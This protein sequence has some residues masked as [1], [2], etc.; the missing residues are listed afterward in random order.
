MYTP[1]MAGSMRLAVALSMVTLAALAIRIAW[2]VWTAP[3]PH[4]LA[5]AD[6]YNATAI[7]LSRGLGY[8]VTFSGDQGFFPG[9]DAS[10]FWPPGYSLF[11]AAFY[12]LFG[13]DLAV[14]RS[15]N[16]IAGAITVVPI[17]FIGRRL[18]DN[19]TGIS[20]A[21][22]AAILPSFIF[23]TP[24]LLSDT[25][26]TLLFATSVACLLQTARTGDQGLNTGTLVAAGVVTGVAALVRGQTFVLIPTAAVW[27]LSSGIRLRQV[28]K[29][30]VAF[31]VLVLLVVT[32][33][34]IRNITRFDSPILLSSNFGY[35][36]R[37]G[38]APYSNGRYVTSQDIWDAEPGI[39]FK[40]REVLSMI[41]GE[42]ARLTMR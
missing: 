29:Y 10:S 19:A 11:L 21:I 3:V 20:A 38:H 41:W 40:Q 27:W 14:A 12:H 9:G 24:V 5:D 26:F 32:P 22:V 39:S 1:S 30:T 8:T 18:F 15:A 7:S 2:S 23:W 31:A 42:S 33:W 17:Y 35:N 37:V 4:G 36:L 34:S 16:A 25:L 13:E 6:Y 28:V